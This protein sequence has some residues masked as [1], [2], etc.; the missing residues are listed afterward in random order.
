MQNFNRYK[1]EVYAD[2]S[3]EETSKIFNETGRVILT[4]EEY[5]SIGKIAYARAEELIKRHK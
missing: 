4:K 1:E 5:I 3:G 2:T